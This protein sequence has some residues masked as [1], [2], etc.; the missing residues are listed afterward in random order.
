MSN[1]L[2]HVVIVSAARTPVGAFMGKLN[3]MPAPRLGALAIA[4]A[5]RRSGIQGDEV[6]EVIMGNVL[7]GGEG[8]APARQAAIFAGLP[9]KVECMTVHKVCGSGLKSVMLAAQGIATGDAE[10]VVAGGMESMSQAPYLLPR[11]RQG[12]RLGHADLLDSMIKDGLWDVYNDTHM[13]NCGERCAQSENISRAD[14]DHY[15]AE[16]YRRAQN[17]QARGW[18]REEIV[19]VSLPQRKGD[20][21]LM[22]D[23]EEPGNAKFDKI[24]QLRPAFQKDGTITAANAS[25]INDGA[26]AVV[27]MSAERARALGLQPM[28]RIVAQASF[29]RAPEEFPLAPI[30]AIQKVLRKAEWSQDS[31]DLF[32]I[33]EAF[34]VV[35]LAAIRTLG[36]DPEKVNVNGGAVAFGHPIGAS[37]TRLLTTI[38]YEM[39]RRSVA[40]GLVTL[41]IGGGEA[42]ALVVERST[43]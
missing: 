7:M 25:K 15:A 30:D 2:R 26:G 31:V 40:R 29:A 35:A 8:Q 19:P 38:L 43:S 17:A 41:C 16:S 9:H 20:P 1:H 24:P 39:R 36:L 32:E 21:I 22:V 34:A 13:G 37:G 6:D 10:V 27:V 18:L 14:Q 12:F 3:Q 11:A 5:V 33:N 23:D 28:A 42:A 4:E